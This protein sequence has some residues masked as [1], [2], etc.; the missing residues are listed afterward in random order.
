[1]ARTTQRQT[2]TDKSKYDKQRKANE[3]KEKRFTKPLKLFFQRKYPAQYDEFVKFF[4]QLENTYHGKKDLTKTGMFREFL[5][6][7]PAQEKSTVSLDAEITVELF[8]NIASLLDSVTSPAEATSQAP[9]AF[10]NT[11]SSQAIVE[12][13]ST[14]PIEV[15]ESSS[16]DQT[17]DII[18]ELVDELFGP[19]GLDQYIDHVENMDEGIDV[20]ILDEL[21]LDLEPF[22]F[23]LETIDF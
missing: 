22:D 2:K 12:A 18:S 17:Q 1:M 3:R 10:P 19:G 16:Q 21:K 13:S 4:N 6:N 15:L 23:E 8:P 7:H 20:N 11:S 5:S 9:T 14:S